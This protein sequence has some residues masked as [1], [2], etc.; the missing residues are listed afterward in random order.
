M[1]SVDGC[2]SAPGIGQ[3]QEAGETD[4]SAHRDK[5]PRRP[6]LVLMTIAWAKEYRNRATQAAPWSEFVTLDAQHEAHEELLRQY[7]LPC[8]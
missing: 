5:R 2:W 4:E 7:E 3:S 6:A 8:C 1:G